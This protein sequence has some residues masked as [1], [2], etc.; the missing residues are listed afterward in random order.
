MIPATPF[1]TTT[2]TEGLALKS[3]LLRLLAVYAAL[4]LVVVGMCIS[5]GQSMSATAALLA[6]VVCWLG[7]SAAHLLGIYP[8]GEVFLTTRLYASSAV[9]IALPVLLLLVVKLR[10]PSLMSG[11]MVYYVILFYLA[12]LVT[13]VA[14]QFQRL[15]ALHS[16]SSITGRSRNGQSEP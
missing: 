11:G 6:S 7:A 14:S 8:R 13:D 15:R 1:Q 4:T 2:A 10:F 12:G 16:R 3:G 5:M 9:R